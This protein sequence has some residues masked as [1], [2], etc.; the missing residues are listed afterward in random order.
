MWLVWSVAFAAVLAAGII[1]R[2]WQVRRA[3]DAY[4]DDET[5]EHEDVE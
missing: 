5:G 3:D 1:H 4:F 2:R